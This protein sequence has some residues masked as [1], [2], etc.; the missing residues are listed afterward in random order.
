MKKSTV[1]TLI[2][3]YIP[4]YV[5][6][7][8]LTPESAKIKAQEAVDVMNKVHNGAFTD[9]VLQDPAT[10]MRAVDAPLMRVVNAWPDRFSEDGKAIEPYE[11]CWEAV[12]ALYSMSENRKNLGKD[13]PLTEKA[14]LEY[15]DKKSRCET[16]IKT[17]KHTPKR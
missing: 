15:I 7:A 13:S 5:W 4:F 2:A 8:P 12:N 9:R 11:L 1:A 16:S 6:S 3:L 14:R 17:G 10:Y